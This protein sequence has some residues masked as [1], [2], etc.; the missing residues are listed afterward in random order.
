MAKLRMYVVHVLSVKCAFD[1]I[2]KV[3]PTYTFKF[4][5]CKFFIKYSISK[6]FPRIFHLS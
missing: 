2:Y 6:N 3:P 5:I 4:Y 1:K